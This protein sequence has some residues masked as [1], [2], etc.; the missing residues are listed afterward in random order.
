L[1]RIKLHH[2]EKRAQKQ[3]SSARK[4][5][6]WLRV[7]EFHFAAYFIAAPAMFYWLTARLAPKSKVEISCFK[8][9]ACVLTTLERKKYSKTAQI[10]MHIGLQA[11]KI[12]R[13]QLLNM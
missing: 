3:P 11:F 10:Y 8:H 4:S 13:K 7:W 12:P 9:V 1:G 5:N 6:R 2:A